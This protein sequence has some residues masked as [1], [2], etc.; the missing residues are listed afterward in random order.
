MSKT[1][2][3]SAAKTTAKKQTQR[4]TP[5]LGIALGVVAVV[6]VVAVIV[7]GGDQLGGAEFGEPAITGNALPAVLD[8]N[9][10]DAAE[11]PAFGMPIPT[12]VGQDFDGD[13]VR[14]EADS[15]QAIL[16]VS[17]SCPHC[18]DEIPEVQ[19]W[20][21]SG[22]GV[23]GVEIVSVSTSANSA[24]SNWPP[25]EWLSRESWQQ[26]IIADDSDNSVFFAYGGQVIPYWVFVDSDGLVTRRNAGRM[27]LASL[28]AAMLEASS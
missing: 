8:F 11:D 27:D 18:Q 10:A 19:S 16:F 14:I 12:V 2:G 5:I 3:R 20:L 9:P 15:P 24:A 1:R 21:D 13:E 26:P 4:R 7:A 22:G 23:P 25:S 28:E 17:H 6:L